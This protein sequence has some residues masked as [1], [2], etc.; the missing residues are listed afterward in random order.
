[1]RIPWNEGTWTHDPANVTEH[2][3]SLSVT[4]VHESDAW[5]HTAYGFVHDTEH[6]LVRPLEV[7]RAVEVD[8][9]C[10]YSGT[11]DQAGIFLKFDDEHWIKTGVEISDGHPMLGGVVTMERSDWS[12]GPVPDWMD[13][14]VTMRLSRWSE[15]VLVRARVDGGEFHLVRLA[16]TPPDQPAVAG[17]FLCAPTNPQLTVEFLEWREVDAD[18]AIH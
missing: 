11:F 7:G 2:G 5:R 6:A 15:S 12:T 13:H 4:A 14:I 16:P 9:R 1:M 8:F 17:P 3:D 10:N 18:A